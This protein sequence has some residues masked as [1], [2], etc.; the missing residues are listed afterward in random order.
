LHSLQTRYFPLNGAVKRLTGFLEAQTSQTAVACLGSFPLFAIKE[1]P[2]RAGVSTAYFFLAISFFMH[3]PIFMHLAGDGH[4][5]QGLKGAFFP[6]GF[7]PYI[8]A[9]S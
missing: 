1:T 7:F 2:D 8:M 9:I 4:P 6:A 3:F 5:A